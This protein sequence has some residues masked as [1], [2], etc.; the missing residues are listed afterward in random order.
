MIEIDAETYSEASKEIYRRI[1]NLFP[2]NH[3]L[4]PDFACSNIARMLRL[5]GSMNY[6]KDYGL[7]PHKVEILE[8]HEEDS[9]LVGQ[10]EYI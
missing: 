7:P 4:R 9:P 6:K 3:E 10:L 1:T 8:Y 5:P 2:E